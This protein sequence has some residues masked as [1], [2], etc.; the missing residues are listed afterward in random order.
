MIEVVVGIDVGTSATKILVFDRDGHELARVRTPSPWFDPVGSSDGSLRAAAITSLV[1]SIEDALDA[2]S[3]GDREVRA[4]GVGIASVAES[5]VLVSPAGDDLTYVIPWYDQRGAEELD[6][7]PPE[8]REE[9]GGVTGLPLSPLCTFAKLLWFRAR[10]L[11]VRRGIWLSLGEYI[12][13]RLSGVMR[14]EPTLVSRT[15]LFRQDSGHVYKRALDAIG[16]RDDVLP[17]LCSAGGRVGRITIGSAGASL[18]GAAVTVAGHDHVVA[19][20][21]NGVT[22]PGNVF[23]SCGTG[24]ALLRVL[25]ADVDPNHRRRLVRDG[26]TQGRHVVEDRAVVMGGTRGGLVLETLLRAFSLGGTDGVAYLDR[27]IMSDLS[28]LDPALDAAVEVIGARAESTVTAVQINGDSVTPIGIWAAGLRHVTAESARLWRLMGGVDAQ[29]ARFSGSGG[30]TRLS[31]FRA[32]KGRIFPGMTFTPF[33]EA[34]A[35]GAAVFAHCAAD[36]GGPDA[37]RHELV[38]WRAV[39]PSE[40]RGGDS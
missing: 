27:E 5:G 29:D 30:W 3:D 13:Y 9:F 31:S 22:E 24:D 4:V 37:A 36:A 18:A 15:G 23:N 16:G 14:S 2:S 17:P 12:A 7:L 28:L 33:A 19:A 32:A 26:L 34:G 40:L 1:K 39:A 20:F 25:E 6:A 38:R 10:G 8:L 21:A 35:L 11:E